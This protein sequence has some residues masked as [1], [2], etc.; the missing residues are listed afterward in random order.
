M[1]EQNVE[2]IRRGFEHFLATG[3]P[4]WDTLDEQVEARDHDIMDGSEYHGHSGVRRWLFEDWASAWAEFSLEPQEYIDVDDERVIAVFQMKATGRASGV[5]IERQ[6]AMVW[7]VRRGLV[8]RI[9]YYNSK[10]Q[11]L[12]AVAG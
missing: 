1:S 5:A 2:L 7:A 12:D 6:D 3:E 10:Q 8:V 11:A 4:A 9:D